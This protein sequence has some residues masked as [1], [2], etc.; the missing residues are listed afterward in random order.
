MATTGVYWLGN[1]GNHWLKTDYGTTNMGPGSLVTSGNTKDFGGIT[2]TRIADPVNPQQWTS[3]GQQVL[4]A[5]TDQNQYYSDGTGGYATGGTGSYAPAP[6]AYDQAVVDQFDSGISSLEAG[7]A[8]LPNQLGIAEANIGTQY[9]QSEN[10]LNSAYQTGLNTYNGSSTGN[11]QSFRTNKNNINDQA[12]GGLRGLLRTLGMYGAVGSDRMLAGNAVSDKATQERSGAGSVY[13]QNQRGLDTNWGN[14]QIADKDQR[15]QLNDWRQ[16][17]VNQVRQQS[18]IT[19]QDL[20]TRLAELRGQRAATI[21][22]SYKGAAQPYLD[23]AKALNDTIDELG[24]YSPAF[25]GTTP[26]YNAPTLDSYNLGQA[27]KMS[28]GQTAG[29]GTPA[30]NAILGTNPQDDEKNKV[31]Y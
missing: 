14:F 4:S 31:V 3:S 21:G 11:M 25:T 16:H 22:G 8:R 7:L 15:T 17:Q 30:I 20:L 26:V 5:N 19:K 24:R 10:R 2:A 27:P 9:N 1:D 29:A 12:S 28:I 23:Q 18:E 13:S 6:P